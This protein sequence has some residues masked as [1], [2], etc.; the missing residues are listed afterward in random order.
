MTSKEFLDKFD[1]NCLTNY[2]LKNIPA[3]FVEDD[4]KTGKRSWNFFEMGYGYLIFIVDYRFFIKLKSDNKIFELKERA[5]WGNT[6]PLSRGLGRL[7][8]HCHNLFLFLC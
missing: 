6:S 2:E 8:L 3:F 5:L 7:Q 1:D 4:K